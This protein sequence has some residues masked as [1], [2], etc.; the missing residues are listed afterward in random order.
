MDVEAQ[1]GALPAVEI[2]QATAV[3]LDD[4]P[5]DSC[6]IPLRVYGAVLAFSDGTHWRL[7]SHMS[8]TV[9]LTAAHSSS[10]LTT[11]GWWWLFRLSVTSR[12]FSLTPSLS[13]SH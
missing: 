12:L 8:A 10:S 3:G 4:D 13:L 2:E 1:Y 7:A 9:H 6:R 5:D 11:W